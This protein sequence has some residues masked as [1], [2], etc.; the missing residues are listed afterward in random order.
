MT[1]NLYDYLMKE[2]KMVTISFSDI[3]MWCG[4]VKY[5]DE[6]GITLYYVY[7]GKKTLHW[8]PWN[9]IKEMKVEE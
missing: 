7:N 3:D 2:N 1:E 6:H 9:K 8:F 4:T 5:Y